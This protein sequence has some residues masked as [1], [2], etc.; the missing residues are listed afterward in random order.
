MSAAA[1]VLPFAGAR[2]SIGLAPA[3][4]NTG[5]Q[6]SLGGLIGLIAAREE[7]LEINLPGLVAGVDVRNLA[8]EL[9]GIGR[10]PGN[11]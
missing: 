9:P 3:P 6:L 11:T 2:C 7:G 4:S 8:L 10:T 5:H 1:V